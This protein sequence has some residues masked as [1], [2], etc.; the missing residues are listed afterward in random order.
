MTETNIT[1]K[2]NVFFEINFF[3]LRIKNREPNIK[4]I[5]KSLAN[6]AKIMETNSSLTNTSQPY[7]EHSIFTAFHQ[8]DGLL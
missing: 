2:V 6:I 7:H 3:M 4:N 5:I 1:K 8:Y